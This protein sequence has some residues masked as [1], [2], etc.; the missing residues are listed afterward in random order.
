MIDQVLID[1][2][3]CPET[4]KRLKL[5]EKTT[6]DQINKLIKSK[7]IKNKANE[8]IENEIQGG[9]ITIGGDH[10]YPIRENIPILLPDESIPISQLSNK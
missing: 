6:I 2:L 10:L 7:V 1:I 5:A 9:L 3:V 4:Q 8:L